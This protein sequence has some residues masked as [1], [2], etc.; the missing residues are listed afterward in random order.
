[1]LARRHRQQEFLRLVKL[2]DS[3]V[4][5]D[6]DLHLGLDNYATHKTPVVRQWLLKHPASTCT[7]AQPAPAGSTSSSGAF[8]ELTSRKL[9]RSA[10]RSVTDT[11]TGARC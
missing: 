11:T 4:P 6:L 2:I 8:A 10:H 7:S 9:R 3:A 1:V 5:E